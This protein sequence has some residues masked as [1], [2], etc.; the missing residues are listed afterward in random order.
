[1]QHAPIAQLPEERPHRDWG[2]IVATVAI[3]A[4]AVLTL[5]VLLQP[6]WLF[7]PAES[8]VATNPELAAFERYQAAPIT[9][10][11]NPELAAFGRYQAAQAAVSS[12]AGPDNPELSA[13][14]RYVE[15]QPGDLLLRANPEVRQFRQWL[16]GQ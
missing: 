14:S 10:A 1:M 11:N 5:I 3:I 2:M 9:S 8:N 4:I 16:E 6:G 13:F 12:I 7:A 15:L